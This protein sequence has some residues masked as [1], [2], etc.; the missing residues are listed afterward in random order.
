M[1]IYDVAAG[2]IIA[3]PIAIGVAIVAG[4]G[5]IIL[6]IVLISKSNKEK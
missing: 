2:P 3:V 5:L 6:A 1:N 4:V